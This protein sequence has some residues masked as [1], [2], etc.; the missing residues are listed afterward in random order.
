MCICK[1]LL[2]YCLLVPTV[3]G[4]YCSKMNSCVRVVSVGSAIGQ[5]SGALALKLLQ[6]L[7]WAICVIAANG[8]AANELASTPHVSDLSFFSRILPYY[9]VSES[10]FSV[11]RLRS[12]SS[13]TNT[14]VLAPQFAHLSVYLRSSISQR[15]HPTFWT[16]DPITHIHS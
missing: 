10:F 4:R 13:H 14:W 6:S 16:D 2:R 7:F 15:V 12:F 8:T 9:F 1:F 3:C 11:P 5:R